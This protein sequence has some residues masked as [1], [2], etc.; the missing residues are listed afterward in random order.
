MA[1]AVLEHVGVRGVVDGE[2]D[3][4]LR[5]VDGGHHA[6]AGEV[7]D[8]VVVLVGGPLRVRVKGVGHHRTAVEELLV[9]GDG[10]LALRLK[11]GLVSPIRSRFSSLNDASLDFLMHRVADERIS[12]AHC[13][14]EESEESDHDLVST[15]LP[16]ALIKSSR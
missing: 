11:Y 14:D 10:L 3:V 16:N 4:D 6:V 9:V 1:H 15:P 5:D 8:V 12:N 13:T 7:Q 2:L